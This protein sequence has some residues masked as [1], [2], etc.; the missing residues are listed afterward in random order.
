MI[1][2]LHIPPEL[3]SRLRERALAHD[4]E[5]LRQI[6]AEAAAPI[7]ESMLR[8]PNKLMNQGDEITLEEFDALCDELDQMP[9]VPS[10]PDEAF[11]RESIY[12]DH[13]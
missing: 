1:I 9:P 2:N 8:E 10:L 12:Q 7:V 3:E 13:P 6:L 4:A 5:G 11:T